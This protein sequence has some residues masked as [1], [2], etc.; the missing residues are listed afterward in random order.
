M[1]LSKKAKANLDM[2]MG[3]KKAADALMAKIEANQPLSKREKRELEI[4]MGDKKSAAEMAND[5]PEIADDLQDAIDDAQA[6][7]D[8]YVAPVAAQAVLDLTAD[9]TLTS[10]ALGAARNTNTFTIQVLAA[11]ANADD[12]VLVDFTG[13]AAAIVCTVTPND[14]TNNAATPVDLSTAQL[15]EL[16]NSGAVV[17]KDIV[18]TDGSSLRALQ[19]ASGGGATALADA[20][21]G[22]AVVGTFSGGVTEVG[23]L[24][25]LQAALAAAQAAANIAKISKRSEDVMKIALTDAES[26]AELK[27]ALEE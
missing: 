18:L 16:L 26:A 24:D 21:E 10:V 4:A 9:I 5:L 13:T 7:L 17:G 6:D 8:A 27:A 22:D 25:A 20:G 3:G 11:A 14:G 2:A 1:A 12:K 19:T 15:A 23:D